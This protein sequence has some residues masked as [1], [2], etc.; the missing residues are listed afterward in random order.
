MV[1][2]CTGHGESEAC[3]RVGSFLLL[4]F[5]INLSFFQ[6]SDEI[7]ASL[8]MTELV[9]TDHYGVVN[10]EC[11]QGRYTYFIFVDYY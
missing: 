2:P 8:S 11:V 3:R 6:F 5:A 10:A 4:I 1:L 9:K 7:I